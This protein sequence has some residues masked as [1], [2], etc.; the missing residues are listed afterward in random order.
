MSDDAGHNATSA[1]ADGYLPSPG[2]YDEFKNAHG[3]LRPHWST[4]L[5]H[6]E[7]LGPDGLERRWDKARHLLHENGVRY[8]VYGDP[9]GM[10]RPW[11][12][13]L[14]PVLLTAEEWQTIERG[15]EQR[16]RLFDALLRDLYGPQ[17]VLLDGVLPPE[18]VFENSGFLRA[19][20]S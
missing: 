17:R 20:H 15:L 19:C 6:I 16:A 2:V 1:L 18:L 12:L 3:G 4:L 10:E 13:S 9:E 11:N 14:L 7:Q 5:E 8:N